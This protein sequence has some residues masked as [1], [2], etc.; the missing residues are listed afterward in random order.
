MFRNHTRGKDAYEYGL[1][2]VDRFELMK[3]WILRQLRLRIAQKYFTLIEGEQF[4]AVVGLF[5]MSLSQLIQVA[6]LFLELYLT[7]MQ[8]YEPIFQ[9]HGY[10][11]MNNGKIMLK[12]LILRIALGHSTIFSIRRCLNR[13]SKDRHGLMLFTKSLC[14]YDMEG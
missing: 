13:S 10:E 11:I 12:Q 5:L 9:I 1:E 2:I 7:G 3:F 4:M 8:A 6:C 14:K